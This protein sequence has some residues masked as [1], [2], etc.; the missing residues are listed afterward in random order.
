MNEYII[1]QVVINSPSY[2]AGLQSGDIIKTINYWP[3]HLLDLEEITRRFQRREGRKIRLK[4]T[5][6]GVE[7]IKCF[8][9]KE[10]I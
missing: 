6:D 5:R 9:L 1:Q 8:K 7:M 3:T 4:I 2:K 10:L